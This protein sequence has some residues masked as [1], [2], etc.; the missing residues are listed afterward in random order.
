MIR[1]TG[2][3]NMEGCRERMRAKRKLCTIGRTELR[4]ALVPSPRAA[5][6]HSTLYHPTQSLVLWCGR[7]GAA[8]TVE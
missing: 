5:Y 6:I 3:G 2:R 1:L 4:A 8:S 7:I